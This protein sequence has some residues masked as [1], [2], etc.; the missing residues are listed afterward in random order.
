MDRSI[1]GSMDGWKVYAAL[2][3][4]LYTAYN[5]IVIVYMSKLKIECDYLAWPQYM[6]HPSWDNQ[7]KVHICSYCVMLS[8]TDLA[9]PRVAGNNKSCEN[10]GGVALKNYS[11]RTKGRLVPWDTHIVPRGYGGG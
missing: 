9:F 10:R 5:S 8:K 3:S 6:M 11:S 1:N 4:I 7:R 2:H